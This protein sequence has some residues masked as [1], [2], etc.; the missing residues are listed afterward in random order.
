MI[1]PVATSPAR[2]AVLG[3]AGAQVGA[4]YRY[5]GADRHG[6]D[7]SGLV[8][9]S[10]AEAGF[11]IPSDAQ[12][13]LRATTAIPFYDVKPADLLFY[14]LNPVQSGSDDGLH[15]GLYVGNG[16]MLHA[17]LNRDEVVL[18]TV[19]NPYWLQRFINAG[20]ILP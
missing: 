17:P 9:F 1:K 15:V 18:E 19:D 13:Q 5:D 12:G 10:Y 11:A 2:A 20:K 4:P 7:A 6:F 14:R 8:F 3:A 16:Q